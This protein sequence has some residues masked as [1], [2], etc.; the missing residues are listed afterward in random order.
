M[1]SPTLLPKLEPLIS[2]DEICKRVGF[3]RQTLR[4]LVREKAFPQPVHLS[5]TR[6]A[7]RLREVEAWI[8]A[9]G[10]KR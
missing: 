2:G 6:L 3:S 7:W 9:G 4:R 10:V 8:E 5:K 1:S